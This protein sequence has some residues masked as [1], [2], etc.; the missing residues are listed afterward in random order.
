VDGARKA[1]DGEPLTIEADLPAELVLP[2]DRRRLRQIVDNL[3]GNAVKYS[4]DGGTI[5][6]RLRPAGRA[7]ELAVS[8]TGIGVS[9]D[10]R[11]KMFTGLYRTSR[12]RDQA[13]PGSGLGLTLSRAVVHR[14]HGT[15]ELTDH[16]GPGTTVLVRLPLEAR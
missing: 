9:V 2:G 5:S 3:L 11:E 10:E 8:D 16:E 13:I 1:V 7:A 14:H 4:P 15:I 6:I 12:A